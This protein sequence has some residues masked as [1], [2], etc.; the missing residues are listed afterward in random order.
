MPAKKST[1]NLKSRLVYRKD[2]SLMRSGYFANDK[3]CG[4]W[5]TY[6]AKG[7]IVKVTIFKPKSK[8]R[9]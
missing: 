7:R 1:A 6:D 4:E 3:Q 9:A 8:P 5:T 2:G